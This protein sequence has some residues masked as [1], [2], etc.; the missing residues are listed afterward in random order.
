MDDSQGTRASLLLCLRDSADRQAWSDFVDIYSRA[1]SDRRQ[2][3]PE[4]ERRA[5]GRRRPPS[6][7]R[8]RAEIHRRHTCAKCR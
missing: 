7:P 8:G 5:S 4:T 1:R 6:P 3:R 2:C